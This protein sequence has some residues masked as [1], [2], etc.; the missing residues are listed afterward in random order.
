LVDGGFG[1][2]EAVDKLLNEVLL[3]L[4]EPDLR[5]FILAHSC[6]IPTEEIEHPSIEET[7]QPVRPITT[8]LHSAPVFSNTGTGKLSRHKPK[9]ST[10]IKTGKTR[11]QWEVDEDATESPGLRRTHGSRSVE[12]RFTYKEYIQACSTS[13]AQPRNEV[14]L[15]ELLGFENKNDFEDWLHTSWVL[16]AYKEYHGGHLKPKFD[17]EQALLDQDKSLDELNN[18]LKHRLGDEK[19]KIPEAR[20]QVEQGRGKHHRSSKGPEEKKGWT[21]KDHDIRFVV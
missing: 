18:T 20:Q 13:R 12:D 19:E 16:R 2:P 7:K 3:K 21:P 15:R 10:L 11:G 6:S 4:I 14:T 8:R 1:R 9:K 17:Q 5:A